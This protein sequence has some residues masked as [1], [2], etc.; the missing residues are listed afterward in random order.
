MVDLLD[1]LRTFNATR[2]GGG[3]VHIT[4]FDPQNLSVAIYNNVQQYFA[5]FD[6]Q[7]AGVVQ[8]WLRPLVPRLN[9][10][11][12]WEA[13]YLMLPLTQRKDAATAAARA[14]DL[15]NANRDRLVGSSG[16]A[17]YIAILQDLRVI[18]QHARLM[19]EQSTGNPTSSTGSAAFNQERD[20][21][22]A[23]NLTWT[24]DHLVSRG[25]VIALAH[26]AHVEVNADERQTM[27][28]PHGRGFQSMGWHL[29]A[30]LGNDYLAIGG[31]F[32]SGRFNAIGSIGGATRPLQPYEAGAVDPRSANATFAAVQ[33]STYLVDLR[34]PTTGSVSTWLGSPQ[35]LRFVGGLYDPTSP[36]DFYE[37]V[38]LSAAYDAI[39]HVQISTPTHLVPLG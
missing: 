17:H 24:R 23:E 35:K 16:E 3:A 34:H 26:N 32:A 36:Q 15:A 6:S 18:A 5:R 22:M 20:A 28:D 2:P 37:T 21:D 33:Q 27:Y 13:T 8:G 4:T 29:H 19:S 30:A 31:S 1:W 25:G 39:L 10:I 9:P 7:D 38:A 12:E 14:Y 11:S